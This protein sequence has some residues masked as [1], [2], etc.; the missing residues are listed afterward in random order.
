MCVIN[1]ATCALNRADRHAV[2][3]VDT[4]RTSCEAGAVRDFK[5]AVDFCDVI[6]IHVSKHAARLIV[7]KHYTF[8]GYPVILRMF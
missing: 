6:G 2:N 3:S 5:P 4:E 7:C 8:A 1:R